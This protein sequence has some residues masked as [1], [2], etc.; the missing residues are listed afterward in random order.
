MKKN[1][2]QAYVHDFWEKY[3]V[4]F[5]HSKKKQQQLILTHKKTPDE[6]HIIIYLDI[7]LIW[8]LL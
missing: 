8:Q 6:E 3:T 7:I 4:T 2:F 1:I 5:V